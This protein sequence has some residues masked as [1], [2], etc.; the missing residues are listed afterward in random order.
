MWRFF[1]F[2]FPPRT[3]EQVLRGVS[4]D[5]FASLLSPRLIE[6]TRPPAVALLPFSRPSVRA[7]IHEAK[8]HG[9]GQSIDYLSLVLTEY[10]RDTQEIGTAVLVPIPLG[11]T[12]QKE[13]GFNQVTEV[14]RK[15]AKE[16][17]RTVDETVLTRTRETVSQV[18]LPRRQREENMRGA[19]SARPLDPSGLY[20]VID[21]VTTTGAT[22]QAAID[23]LAHAGALHISPLALAH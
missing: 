13:R 19:F 9:S 2:L 1:D 20:I 18:S 21:D 11:P 12:R 3:D 16:T 4:A 23:A 14:V 5:Q 17:G 7:A 22:L 10:L 8:Y 15:A 6:T